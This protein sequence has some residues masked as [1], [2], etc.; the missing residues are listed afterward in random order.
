MLMEGS[1][2]SQTSR[3]E[4]KT[5]GQTRIKIR[6][7]KLPTR[8]GEIP[9]NNLLTANHPGGGW[10]NH[11]S[12]VAADHH[13][14]SILLHI[15]DPISGAQ[16]LIDT[17]A[18]V[19]VIP[20]TSK[21]RS[22][23]RPTRTGLVAA[24]GSPIKSFGTRQ[25]TIKINNQLYSW[26]FHIADVQQSILGADFL[27]AKGFLVD[28]KRRRIIQPDKLQIV[29]GVFK[30]VSSNICSISKANSNEFAKLLHGRADLI[31]PTFSL[32]TPKHGVWHHIVTHGPPVHAH[33]R[34]L[35]QEKLKPTKEEY[36]I[37]E[38]LGIVR[39][40][41]LPYSSPIH[42][43]AKPGGGLSPMRRFPEVKLPDGG[44]QIPDTSDP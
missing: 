33:P 1:A 6:I 23:P 18:E 27:Q 43:V 29:N 2:G 24:N 26:R 7:G 38:E 22:R 20:P 19:S 40:S 5:D 12:P 25:S 42:V 44:R 21:E 31:T 28:L 36:R 32:E 3:M 34:R 4:A 13:A 30:E 9:I 14:K 11:R 37:L 17:G 41:K 8:S 39:R 10:D 15:R 16:F 35:P